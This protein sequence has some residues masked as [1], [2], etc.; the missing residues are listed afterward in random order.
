MD[1]IGGESL[2]LENTF[3]GSITHV[4]HGIN[5]HSSSL[6]RGCIEEALPSGIRT[7]STSQNTHELDVLA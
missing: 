3:Q 4:V 7:G 5:R 6:A 1:I 2:E